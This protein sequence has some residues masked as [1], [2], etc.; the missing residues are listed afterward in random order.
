M[1]KLLLTVLALALVIAMA[2][3][4]LAADELLIYDFADADTEG[5]I[6]WNADMTNTYGIPEPSYSVQ[7]GKLAITPVGNFWAGTFY[8]D[9]ANGC[10][11]LNDLSAGLES[12]EYSYIRLYVKNNL[13]CNDA[14][15]FGFSFSLQKM[16]TEGYVTNWGAADFSK[17]VFL[18]MDGTEA[19]IEISPDE[20]GGTNRNGYKNGYISIP[21]GFE[22]YIFMSA[23]L[24]DF[25]THT[26]WGTTALD[27]L[28]GL[29]RLEIDVRAAGTD[30]DG[31]TNNLILDDLALVKTAEIPETPGGENPGQTPDDGNKDDD[32]TDKPGSDGDISIMLYAAAA[33]SGL[34]ALAIRKRK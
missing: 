21:A 11:W 12:G 19:N 4:A 8:F 1:K 22:G 2:I 7:D 16:S 29:G 33:I 32:N 17:A 20:K 5:I 31:S 28:N 15:P 26:Q 25:P 14:D 27:N 18:N 23:K 3:P 24:E 6:G 10:S 30:C 13:P 9:L 34:G